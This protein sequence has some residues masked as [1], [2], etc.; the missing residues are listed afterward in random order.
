MC[1]ALGGYAP[2]EAG[3]PRQLLITPQSL[4]LEPV[5]GP[6]Q[7]LHVHPGV[8]EEGRQ[9]PGMEGAGEDKPG[10]IAPAGGTSLVL[11]V[12]GVA[13]PADGQAVLVVPLEQA[14]A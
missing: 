4:L 9:D 14:T 8:V 1:W 3:W 10:G 7:A 5:P 12:V 6:D 13:V 2:P 11:R